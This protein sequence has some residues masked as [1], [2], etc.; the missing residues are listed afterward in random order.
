MSPSSPCPDSPL[1]CVKH[2]R[3]VGTCGIVFGVIGKYGGQ[4]IVQVD[5]SLVEKLAEQDRGDRLRDGGDPAAVVTVDR[6]AAGVLAKSL[7][8]DDHA[9]AGDERH[10][11]LAGIFGPTAAQSVDPGFGIGSHAGLGGR[12]LVE[13]GCGLIP[14]PRRTQW[15]DLVLQSLELELQGQMKVVVLHGRRFDVSLPGVPEARPR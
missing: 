7:V 11:R 4:R 3:N 2:C 10:K 9:A 8:S 1:V 14:S 12:T 6:L 5:Q 13:H 15:P